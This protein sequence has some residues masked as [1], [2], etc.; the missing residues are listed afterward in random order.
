[1]TFLQLLLSSLE[2]SARWRHGEQQ[3][4]TDVWNVHNLLSYRFKDR[5][6]D[7][8][9][10]RQTDSQT[11]REKKEPTVVRSRKVKLVTVRST[12]EVQRL[13]RTSLDVYAPLP[14]IHRHTQIETQTDKHTT[15]ET[16]RQTE[17]ERKTTQLQYRTS[18][19]VYAPLP[20]IQTDRHKDI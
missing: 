10:K 13:Y 12:D 18:L 3:I 8:P 7:R 15:T 9:I 4:I 5:Q 17:E 11:H 1:L 2:L 19:G 20:N 16:D 14:S 6:T